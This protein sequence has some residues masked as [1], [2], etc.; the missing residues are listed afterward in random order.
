L[1]GLM[2]DG[3]LLSVMGG[4]WWLVMSELLLLLLRD[5]P[6]DGLIVVSGLMRGG[7]WL[8]R[9]LGWL[10]FFLHLC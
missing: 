7:W 10:F 6:L 4:W 9:V 8:V 5:M 3:R 2:V 1:S